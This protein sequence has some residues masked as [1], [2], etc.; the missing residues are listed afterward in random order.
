[1]GQAE[2]SISAI[3]D[4]APASST[5]LWAQMLFELKG[6]GRRVQ[7]CRGSLPGDHALPQ[8]SHRDRGDHRRRAFQNEPAVQMVTDQDESNESNRQ[9]GGAESESHKPKCNAVG[10]CR[11]V[12]LPG[13]KSSRQ[14]R[15][16]HVRSLR[17]AGRNIMT[18]W[19]VV[20]AGTTLAQ[21]GAPRLDNWH[22]R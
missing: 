1:V 13:S 15:P 3:Q 16:A 9:R 17:P 8:C 20:P 18:Q 6:S 5:G 11:A 10:H 22:Y 2:E 14:R 19:K 12:G 7:E 21:R 4:V